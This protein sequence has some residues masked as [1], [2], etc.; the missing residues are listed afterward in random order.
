MSKVVLALSDQAFVSLNSFVTMMVVAKFC[1]ADELTVYVLAWSIL[2]FFRVIEERMLASP[3]VV[4]AHQADR[5]NSAFLGSSLVQQVVFSVASCLVFLL[6]AVL[7]TSRQ[8]PEGLS[9][10]FAVIAIAIGPILLRDHLRAVS[11]THFRYAPA[12]LMSGSA[13]V[14]QLLIMFLAH[15]YARLTPNI[16]FAAMG[17]ASLL[18][19]VVWLALKTEPYTFIRSQFLKDWQ[20]CFSYSRWLVAARFFPNVVNSLL[21]WLVLWMVSKEASGIWGSCTT[22]ANVSMMFVIGCNNLFQP[23]A[24]VA[25]QTTGPTAMRRVLESSAIVFSVALS[26]VCLVYLFAGER[27]LALAFNETLSQYGMVVTLLSVHVLICSLS[28]VAGNGLAA[29]EKSRGIF[30]GE[31]AWSVVTVIAAIALT[32]PFGLIGTAVAICIGSL[33][34]TIVEGGW[35][36][37]WLRSDRF[38]V[39]ESIA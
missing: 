11:C 17:V 33:T 6:L 26:L 2:C 28:I 23:R 22:L 18:P 34:A 10:A 16:V 20:V 21:P 27:L 8:S 38:V 30:A 24:V 4:F 19:A 5:E 3:Y 25:L 29:M 36:I 15:R 1:S 37:Y 9:T 14:L 39:Q 35:L 13:L 32:P 12:A 7:F 31:F